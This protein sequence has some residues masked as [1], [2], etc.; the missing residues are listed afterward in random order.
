MRIGLIWS[1]YDMLPLTEAFFGL[2]VHL[3][4]YIDR[5]HRPR[6][7]KSQVL[8]LEQAKKWVEYLIAQWVEKCIVPPMLEKMLLDIY[9]EYILPLFD[10]YMKEMVCAHSLVGKLWFLC[11]YADIDT[12]QDIITTYTKK[13][14]LTPYQSKTKKFHQNRPVWKKVVPMWTYFLT[15]YGKRDWMVRKS[16]KHD[17]RYFKDSGVD[18][19]IPLSRG[20]LFYTKIL[21]QHCNWKKIRFHGT[22]S[23]ATCIQKMIWESSWWYHCTIYTT[24][25]IPSLTPENKWMRMLGRG[26][27]VEVKRV[28]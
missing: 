4:I 5:S 19:L 12:A 9:P 7:D 23:V 11:E 28:D 15:T 16:I 6:W 1:W 24:C 20:F 14:T 3:H 22:D 2:D 27:D 21:H 17:I 10:I 25:D 13:A 8:R 18:T 26:G